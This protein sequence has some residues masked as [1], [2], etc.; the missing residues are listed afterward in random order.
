MRRLRVAQ[1]LADLRAAEAARLVT[2]SAEVP[3]EVEPTAPATALVEP[4]DLEA[5]G[6]W[7][8]QESAAR[9]IAAMLR[10]A[11]GRGLAG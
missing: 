11:G 2:V 9:R 4:A 10:T 6:T 8:G 7:Q 3:A 5:G 1:R